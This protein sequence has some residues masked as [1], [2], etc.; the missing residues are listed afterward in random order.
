MLI[1]KNEIFKLA[2]RTIEELPFVTESDLK[3]SAELYPDTVVFGLAG[4]I[5]TSGILDTFIEINDDGEVGFTSDSDRYITIFLDGN[6]ILDEAKAAINDTLESFGKTV[7]DVVQDSIVITNVNPDV[8]AYVDDIEL[9]YNLYDKYVSM[10]DI[11]RIRKM[12]HF[13]ANFEFPISN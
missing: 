8:E 1:L 3:I 6:Y 2:Y 4:T 12:S 13:T 10:E 11:L 7:L 9:R 5:T